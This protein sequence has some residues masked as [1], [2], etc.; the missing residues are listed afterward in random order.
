[1]KKIKSLFA[2][3]IFLLTFQTKE[4]PIENSD[5]IVI[6]IQNGSLAADVYYPFGKKSKGT[7]LTINGLAPKGNKDPRFVKANQALQKA[8]YTVV[9]PFFKEIC[10]YKISL[11]NVQDI[12]DSILYIAKQKEFAKDG[13]VALFAPSFSGALSLI[14]TSD[15]KVA[16]HVQAICCIGTYGNVETIL[17]NLF[18]IQEM[19]EYGRMVLLYNFLPLS[20]GKKPTIMKAIELAL[21]D[22]YNKYKDDSF[23]NYFA[24][25][26]KKDRDFFSRIQSDSDFRMQHWNTILKKGGKDR[27][28]LTELSV[29]THIS[30]MNIPTLLVHGKSDD[31]VPSSESILVYDLLQKR[32]VKSKL[33]VTTLISHG[34]TGFSL[35]SILEIPKVIQSFAFFFEQIP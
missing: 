35:K 11:R 25:M 1:M 18:S 22:N 4:E 30:K 7:I 12:K 23:K 29:V 10:E 32:N 3:I 9:C 34:D 5:E 19:D 13:K 15:E 28:L 2:S 6:P 33:C 27:I 17:E 20:I 14:A 31:V 8:G 16:K 24:S 26:N 21:L